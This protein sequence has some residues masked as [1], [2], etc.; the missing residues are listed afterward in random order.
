MDLAQLFTKDLESLSMLL[1][2]VHRSLM[3]SLDA[4]TCAKQYLEKDMMAALCS[5]FGIHYYE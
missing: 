5:I 4:G 2:D 3:L 1:L